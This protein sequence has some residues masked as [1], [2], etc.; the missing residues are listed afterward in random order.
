MVDDMTKDGRLPPNARLVIADAKQM[1]TYI[2]TEHGLKVLRA[3][4]EELKQ[5]GNLTNN[6]DI[7]MIVEAASIVM[8]WNLFEYGDCFFKQLICTAMGTPAAVLWSIIYYYPHEKHKLIPF[9]GHKMPLLVRFI[10]DTFLIAKFGGDNGFSPS[11]WNQFT[12]T[13][14]T[15]GILK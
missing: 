15:Y 5:E 14:N 4:L 7:E 13:M 6:F 12:T 1:Y 8:R 2:D 10:D 3:F 11:E 9:A